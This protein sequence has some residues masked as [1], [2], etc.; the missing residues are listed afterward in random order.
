[1]KGF[2]AKKTKFKWKRFW[3]L[4]GMM[5]IPVFFGVIYDVYIKL[6]TVS[7][8]F[9]D[10]AG[11]SFG[12]Y[13]ITWAFEQLA[14]VNSD[15]FAALK[16]FF[17]IFLIFNFFCMPLQVVMSYFFHKKIPATV[18]FR[19]VFYLPTLLSP[20]IT[21]TVFGVFMDNIYGLVPQILSK[22]G[23][24]ISSAQGLLYSPNTAFS[25]L[26]FYELWISLGVSTLI[27][28]AA[29]N[30]VPAEVFEAARID[31]A[32][33]AQELFRIV[34]PMIS[35]ILSVGFLSNTIAGFNIYSEILLLTDPAQS[36]LYTVAYIITERAKARQY[37]ASAGIGFVFTI[38]AIP[39]IGG[40]RWMFDKILPDV[41]Y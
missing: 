20:V 14:D 3:F 34:F 2:T 23:V 7:F 9:K 18:F 21:S 35:G 27:Y 32:N 29:I 26:I 24:H 41:S 38:F 25:S 37:F 30:K 12:F 36:K 31:G 1:M 40:F 33:N 8:M 22:M 11:K 13:Y 17:Y 5:A 4:F 16:Y 19:V 10:Q 6:Q 28:T 15:V 39:L